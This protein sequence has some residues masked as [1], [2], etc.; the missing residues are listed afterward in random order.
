[1]SEFSQKEVRAF[2][3]ELRA[4]MSKRMLDDPRDPAMKFAVIMSVLG[5][6]MGEVIWSAGQN[7]THRE[8]LLSIAGL[9]VMKHIETIEAQ[10]KEK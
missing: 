6:M 9:Q 10:E 3:T 1:M 8:S 5:E 7:H 2:K 4:V